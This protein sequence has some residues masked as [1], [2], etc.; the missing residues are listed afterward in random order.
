MTIRELN[1]GHAAAVEAFRRMVFNVMARNCD[2][3]TKNFSFLMRKGATWEFSPAYDVT[4]SHNPNGEWTNQ[5]LMSLNGK[6]KNFNS[7]DFFKIADRFGIGG[8]SLIIGDVKNALKEWNSFAQMA[9]LKKE[10]TE[11]IRGLHFNW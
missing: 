9:G 7:D 2:D 11:W 3:H 10:E 1:L 6:Y 8:A 5:H 4:F